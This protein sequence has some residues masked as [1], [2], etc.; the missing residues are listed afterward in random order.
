MRARIPPTTAGTSDS[1]DGQQDLRHVVVASLRCQAIQYAVFIGISAGLHPPALNFLQQFPVR[2]ARLF[3]RSNVVR[4]RRP[5]R[6]T[7][8]AARYFRFERQKGIPC[9]QD[10]ARAN[11]LQCDH[12]TQ[13]IVVRVIFFLC[14]AQQAFEREV[15]LLQMSRRL[16]RLC[17]EDVAR[18]VLNDDTL[19]CVFI[20]RFQRPNFALQL[21]RSSVEPAHFLVNA[22]ALSGHQFNRPA[23]V[24]ALH[25]APYL[26]EREP[27]LLEHQDA[28]Q[29]FKLLRRVVAIAVLG[30]DKA[31]HKNPF[32]VVI[33]ERLLGKPAQFRHLADCKTRMHRFPS[34][35][36]LTI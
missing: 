18:N 32:P 6:G 7:S 13:L 14:P 17:R 20:K 35:R 28:V 16:D 10:I 9:A 24:P 23:V 22:L 31:R 29:H 8:Q 4:K 33:D 34:S 26:V 19:L 25:K 30:V 36:P 21:P 1:S 11:V 12:R 2:H 15:L 3:V 5:P 27:H